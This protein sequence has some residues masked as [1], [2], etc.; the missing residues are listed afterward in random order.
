LFESVPQVKVLSPVDIVI[1]HGGN[2]TVNESLAAGKPLLLMP[3]GGEQG[4]N[5]SRVVYLGVGLR[6]DIKRSTSQ[7][8][9]MK[10]RYLIE[11]LAFRKSAE[12]IADILA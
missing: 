2:N 8:I 4:D 1:S 10:V 3:V 9:S 11:E 12:K 7:E 6:A 5:A